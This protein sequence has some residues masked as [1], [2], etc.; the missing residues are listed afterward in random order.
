MTPEQ[1]QRVGELYDAAMELAP[2]ARSDFLAE[3]CG[4]EDELRREVE[5]LL[6]ARE[7]ADGFIAGKVAGAIAEMAGQQ[8]NPSLP[9]SSSPSLALSLAQSLVGQSLS[10]YQALSL[11]GV[12]GMGEVYLAEDTR[13]DRRVAI[14][15]LPAGLTADAERVRRFSREARAASALNHPNIITIHEIGEADGRHFIVTE[16]VEGETL[17]E[18]MREAKLRLAAALDIALQVASALSATHEAGI[19][20]RDIKPENLMLRRDGYVKVLDFGLAK[21]AEASGGAGQSEDAKTSPIL[22]L[23][24]SP[25]PPLYFSTIPGMVMGTAHYMSPEQARGQKVDGRSDLFSLGVVL[26]EM[27]AGRPPF[28]GVNAIEVLGAILNREPPPLAE[29][30][31]EAPPSLARELE[32]IVAKALSKDREERYQTSKDLLLDLKA[33]KHELEFQAGL[34]RAAQPEEKEAQTSRIPATATGETRPPARRFFRARSNGASSPRS[35][36]CWRWPQRR[37][38][39]ASTGARRIPRSRLIPSQSCRS[40]TRIAPRRRSTSRMV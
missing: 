11:L 18:R 10:H 6:R 25:A 32:R 5:S 20:H 24:P 9:L 14:K 15:L 40:L 26:Y 36:R 8:Q 13:L 39:L 29:H 21:L 27:F 2:E 16:Y 38:V 17:R 19:V 34:E 1:Y 35:S 28:G 12:G 31:A 3:A 22:P 7:Q 4:G 33:V 23:S 37:R 30:L